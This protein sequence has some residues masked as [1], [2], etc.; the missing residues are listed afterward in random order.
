MKLE[1]SR[2]I[3]EEH[4]NIKFRENPSN[5][6]R[7][8]PYG[9]RDMTKLIVAFRNFTNSPKKAV[10][11]RGGLYSTAHNV[12]DSHTPGWHKLL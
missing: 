7:V 8:V 1:F 5:G 4:S 10:G 11:G 3:F 9:R 6:S 12:L 2:E